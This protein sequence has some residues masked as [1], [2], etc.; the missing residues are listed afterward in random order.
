MKIYDISLTDSPDLVVW[1]GDPKIVLERVSKIEDGANHNGSRLEMSVHSGTHV[2]APF[3]FLE[4]GTTVESL[5]LDVLMGPVQV[6]EIPDAD[7]INIEAL[8]Y[9]G[10]KPGTTRVLF[11]TRNSTYWANQDTQFETSFVGVAA[12]GAEYLVWQGIKL[13]GL[14]YLSI[15]PYHKSRE[16]HQTLLKHGVVIV[17]GLDLSNVPAGFYQLYCLPVK[18][19]GSDG[20]PARAVLVSEENEENEEEEE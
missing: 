9:A 4:D 19:K 5:P 17:E 11:K 7:E 8:T 18:L 2:D 14:D 10:I 13:V 12:D 3:H 20:A 1:P 16:T 6:V 15:S